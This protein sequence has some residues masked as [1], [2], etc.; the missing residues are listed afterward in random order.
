MKITINRFKSIESVEKFSFDGFTLLAG[1]NSSGKSS[2]IQALMLLK[3][4]LETTEVLALR[5]EYVSARTLSELVHNNSQKG[6]TIG[7]EWDKCE[8]VNCG[9]GMIDK[10]SNTKDICTIIM[11]ITFKTIDSAI[12]VIDF[13]LELIGEASKDS[14]NIHYN[15]L[16]KLYDLTTNIKTVYSGIKEVPNNVR[17]VSVKNCKVDF[18]NFFPIFVSS[19]DEG[20]KQN[21]ISLWIL[22]DMR[23][24]LVSYLKTIYYVGPNRVSP[25][26]DRYYSADT[27][28]NQVDSNGTNTRFILA[29]RKNQKIGNGTLNELVNKWVKIL[30]LA[31]EV[32]SDKNNESKI[33]TTSVK[34]NGKLNVDLCNTGFGNSQILPIIVQGLLAPKGSL[35][36]IE[37]PEVHMHP[38]VQAAMTDFFIS[39]AE[40]GKNVIIET[41]SDHIVTRI[42]RRV[43]EKPEIRN[44][45]HVCFVENFDGASEYIRLDMDDKAT[46]T[47]YPYLPKGFMDSQDEDYRE[48]MKNKMSKR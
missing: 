45:I 44:F 27:E 8:L 7:M 21:D 17:Q 3:Q 39:M 25:D 9:F 10:F 20:L 35:V 33:Y 31:Q 4:T 29:E 26:L 19:N 22:K 2:L 12:K 30:G 14:L 6:T 43:S 40:D 32:N 46:F 18:I 47:A 34:V 13:K 11:Q 41:H 1:S 28:K 5:G 16:R 24:L 15:S 23:T 36:I 37:D 48:I 42:R 38:A